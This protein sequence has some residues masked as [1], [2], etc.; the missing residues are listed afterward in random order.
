M[1][2]YQKIST[3]IFFTSVC[4]CLVASTVVA[5]ISTLFTELAFTEVAQAQ[6]RRVRYVP[7]SN[8]DA[9]K[10]SA[11]GISRSGCTDTD[12]QKICLIALL[13]DLKLEASPIPQTI[14]ERPTIYL[15]TPKV[16]KS[17]IYLRIDD[18]SGLTTKRIYRNGFSINN[19]SGIVAFKI[20]DDAPSL[21]VN[22]KYKLQFDIEYKVE[23]NKTVYAYIKRVLPSPKL[24]EQLKTTTKPIEVAALYAQE[25]LW[26]ETLQTLAEAQRTVPQNPEITEEW[27]ELLK[28]AKINRA[29]SFPLVGQI[30][31][32]QSNTKPSDT[33][34][35]PSDMPTQKPSDTTS[36]PSDATPK[37]SNAM[38]N[39]YN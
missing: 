21:E 38:P 16:D 17:T 7:P 8:L 11:S 27:L 34:P 5:P 20:P 3:K 28:S 36:K 9:P 35:K 25:G 13:P 18:E 30:P 23:G 2:L 29:L 12:D 10:V 4:S 19:E 33:A 22:K 1:S 39:S 26:F 15:L 32:S 37:P 31:K 6:S 14:S 24:V